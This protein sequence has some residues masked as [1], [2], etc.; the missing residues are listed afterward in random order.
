MKWPRIHPVGATG[1]L[2]LLRPLEFQPTE[3]QALFFCLAHP[4]DEW[5]AWSLEP[6]GLSET[7]RAS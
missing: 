2:F 3:Q 7:L 1:R 5:G 6:G 4:N